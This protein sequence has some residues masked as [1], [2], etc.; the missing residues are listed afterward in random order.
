MKT[1][2]S[3]IEFQRVYQLVLFFLYFTI[4]SLN[5]FNSSLVENLSYGMMFVA[6]FMV[7]NGTKKQDINNTYIKWLLC[8]FLFAVLSCFW[9]LKIKI[10]FWLLSRLLISW[11][12]AFFV[13]FYIKSFDDLYRVL[14]YFFYSNVVLTFYIIIVVGISEL[15]KERVGSSQLGE[16]WNSNAIGMSL[17][18]A[19][20]SLFVF[21][22]RIKNKLSKLFYIFLA[23]LMLTLLFYTGSR[24]ALFLIIA[25][26]GIFYFLNNRKN[27][28]IKIAA[29]SLLL[30][31]VLY[32]IMNVPSFYNVMGE[33][34]ERAVLQFQAYDGDTKIEG[35]SFAR[36][37]LI[38][39]GIEWFKEK[40]LLG[41][42]VN[43][44]RE[45]SNNTILFA[46]KNFYAHNNLVELLVGVGIFGFL[47]F[48]WGYMYIIVRSLKERTYY[49]QLALTL[50]FVLFFLDFATVSYYSILSN[51]F[52]CI[53][54]VLVKLSSQLSINNKI[55][56][57]D[58]ESRCD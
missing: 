19:V 28:F 58:E 41:Y 22:N 33:R 17:I 29:I 42:G 50:I 49:S 6:L 3:T 56:I 54:F 48:Y 8:F 51:F 30:I 57:A 10:A 32:L 35:S 43:N 9:A 40:P 46:G 12:V 44:Y 27:L 20:N 26:L 53:A 25:P 5:Y 2:S 7:M 31:V 39:Y 14:K 23:L 13:Y 4:Y 34:I 24:K 18:F 36:I 37:K 38:E 11:S 55:K 1:V 15:G 45:L 52:I 16:G 21:W 47:I